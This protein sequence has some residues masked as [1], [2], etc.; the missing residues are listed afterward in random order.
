MI[1]E[2]SKNVEM[3]PLRSQPEGAEFI[4]SFLTPSRT[5]AYAGIQ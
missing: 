3:A 4:R 2:Q 5:P 1:R